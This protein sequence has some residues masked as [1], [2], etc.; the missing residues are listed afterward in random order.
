MAKPFSFQRAAVALARPSLATLSIAFLASIGSVSLNDTSWG[1]NT[2]APPETSMESLSPEAISFFES[3]IRPVLIEHCYR[4]HSSDG[5]AIRGGLSL[6]HRDAI[7]AGGESGPAIV[8][9][10]LDESV[11]WDA[12]NHRGMRMPPNAK[13]P[14]NIIEDFKIWIEMGAPDPR[15]PTGVK[16]QSQVTAEDIEKGRSFWSFQKPTKPPVPTPNLQDWPKSDVDR[17]IAATWDKHDLQPAMDTSASTLVR[18][19]YVDLIGFLPDA[20]AVQAFEKAYEKSPDDAVSKA[21]DAL[22]AKP[23][24]G[25]RWGRHWL[26][27]ARYAESTG[28]EVDATFPYAWRYR[29]FVIDSFQQDKPYDHFVRQQVAGD[30]L[31]APTDEVWA[32]N[33]IATGF[34]AI[35][36]KSLSEQSPRQ[37]KADLVDEQIDATTRVILGVSVACAMP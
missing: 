9:H 11:L 28:K 25:E 15:I 13:L 17:F 27:V 33:L 4:C 24:F 8:P 3:K 6:D 22:L 34:L 2:E 29:D 12:I 7:L 19:L 36:P 21:V 31:P 16:V 35:G 10:N 37:F 5:Q 20:S 32:E 18:R 1:Q 30:L 14:P 26:D 23:E